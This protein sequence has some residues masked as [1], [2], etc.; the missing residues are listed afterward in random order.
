MKKSQLYGLSGFIYAIAIAV[1]LIVGVMGISKDYEERS[2]AGMYRFYS[3]TAAKNAELI[4]KMFEQERSYVIDESLFF[5]GAYGG[6]HFKDFLPTDNCTAAALGGCNICPS[7]SYC[8][9]TLDRCVD[10]SGKIVAPDPNVICYPGDLNKCGFKEIDVSYIPE[11]FAPYWTSQ[12]CIPTVDEMKKNF[13]NIAGQMF[14]EPDQNIIVPIATTAGK[15]IGFNYILH[16]E[17]FGEGEV[18]ADWFPQ[19]FPKITLSMPPRPAKPVAVYDFEI[20]VHN[21]KKTEFFDLYEAAKSLSDSSNGFLFNRLSRYLPSNIDQKYLTK[22]VN[23]TAEIHYS[24][25][26]FDEAP[27]RVL[28]KEILLETPTIFGN[29]KVVLS[30]SHCAHLKS[31]CKN[32]DDETDCLNEVINDISKVYGGL[33]CTVLLE[34][35]ENYVTIKG[36]VGCNSGNDLDDT[37]M[38]CIMSRV[39]SSR[40]LVVGTPFSPPGTEYENYNI[41]IRPIDFNITLSAMGSTYKYYNTSCVNCTVV[42]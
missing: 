26:S 35:K 2:S 13:E 9:N 18:V 3:L 34:L 19:G 15:P 17:R 29:P 21:E 1:M 32:P 28:A 14:A 33:P 24:T 42:E 39:A 30:D 10:D 27:F 37:M 5:I 6:Y 8:D 4:K 12:D 11:K 31:F 23:E 16:L 41:N 36:F 20:F 25:D 7:G 38:R 40:N 22:K